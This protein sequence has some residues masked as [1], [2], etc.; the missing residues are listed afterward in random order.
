[1]AKGASLDKRSPRASSKLT[2]AEETLV[3]QSFLDAR[4]R[5]HCIIP[6]EL[7]ERARQGCFTE[8]VNLTDV[9]IELLDKRFP[10]K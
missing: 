3:N 8:R 1:M 2:S 5:I 4:A 7:R 6:G 10:A 9:I